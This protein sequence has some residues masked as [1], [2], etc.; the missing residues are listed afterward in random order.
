LLNDYLYS[1]KCAKI[2]PTW[3]V[4]LS[5]ILW[6]YPHRWIIWLQYP[7]SFFQVLLVFV[8]FLG[9]RA[10]KIY[11]LI[12]ILCFNLY[13]CFCFSLDLQL[14]IFTTFWQFFC[15]NT[16]DLW[17]TLVLAQRGL[18]KAIFPDFLNKNSVCNLYAWKTSFLDIKS[19]THILWIHSVYCLYYKGLL[20]QNLLKSFQKWKLQKGRNMGIS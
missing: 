12:Y 13:L 14:N 11:I 6:P 3:L 20:S 8:P 7:S 18:M 17:N 4:E 2:F 19:L 10:V 1:F 5:D 15:W 16:L 9:P